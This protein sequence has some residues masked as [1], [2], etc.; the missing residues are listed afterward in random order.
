MFMTEKL[1]VSI[2]A[3]LEGLMGINVPDRKHK[4]ANT[5]YNQ[6]KELGYIYHPNMQ[7]NFGR[8]WKH[9][10]CPIQRRTRIRDFRLHLFETD[11]EFEKWYGEERKRQNQMIIE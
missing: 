11:E 9:I 5:I 6:I 3:F 4:V 1:N 8:Y 10:L 2:E 7:D